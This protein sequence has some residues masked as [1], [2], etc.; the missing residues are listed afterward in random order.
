M[1]QHVPSLAAVLKH[2]ARA[3]DVIDRIIL[4]QSIVTVMDRDTPLK[5]VSGRATIN[6][7]ADDME[8]RHPRNSGLSIEMMSMERI[9]PYLIRP[10]M[11]HLPLCVV[12]RVVER[13]G[14]CAAQVAEEDIPQ[15]ELDMPG[16]K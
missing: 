15:V 5:Q 14:G 12:G 3:R 13:I 8:L 7:V 6:R 9:A 11:R 1:I 4:H 10:D 16:D 2:D